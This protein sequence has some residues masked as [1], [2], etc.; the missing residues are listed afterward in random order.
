MALIKRADRDILA[1]DAVVLD[2]GDLMAQGEA[3]K[4]H[5]RAEADRIL[6]E[7]RAERARIM[8]GA[9][10][11]ARA[12]GF[13]QGLEEGLRQGRDQGRAEII[14]EYRGTLEGID[15]AWRGA[16]DQFE[17][18]RDSM[19]RE[20]RSDVVRLAAEVA[21]MVTRR[22]V[23]LRDDVV[24]DQLEA[25]LSLLTKSTGLTVVV[26]PRDR[27]LVERVMPGLV[28][29]FASASHA[30]VITDE[31]LLPGSCVVRTDTGG[32]IDGS[33]QTQLDRIVEAMVPESGPAGGRGPA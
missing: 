10:E 12:S 14:E 25:A 1:R 19:L 8:A 3:I 18:S 22:V 20:A 33:I 26:T 31:S 29:R 30:R 7:A 13:E 27:E 23:E 6:E 17:A 21:Q 32:E 16:L 4:A 2:L 15:K 24:A 28:E 11:E 9:T 5:A